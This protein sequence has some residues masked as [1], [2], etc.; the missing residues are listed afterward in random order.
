MKQ[1]KTRADKKLRTRE[2]AGLIQKTEVWASMSI[3]DKSAYSC[4]KARTVLTQFIKTS[5]RVLTPVIRK[6]KEIDQPYLCERIK[7]EHLQTLR[8][9]K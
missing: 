4:Q 9:D 2:S 8:L 6:E 7:S 5:P 3:F 1:P